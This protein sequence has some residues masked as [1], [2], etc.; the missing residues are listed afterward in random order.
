MVGEGERRTFVVSAP[1]RPM[2]RGNKSR[3]D[4]CG[5]DASLPTDVIPALVAGTHVSTGSATGFVRDVAAARPPFDT[6]SA[7]P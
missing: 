3:D 6:Q 7:A 4:N 1:G 2:D 5:H